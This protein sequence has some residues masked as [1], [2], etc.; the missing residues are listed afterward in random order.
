[1]KTSFAVAS[2]LW[3]PALPSGAFTVS[4]HFP[5]I[6]SHR[7]VVGEDNCTE[8]GAVLRDHAYWMQ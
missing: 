4:G 5:M 2:P 3:I 8:L 7:D 6:T 1:M